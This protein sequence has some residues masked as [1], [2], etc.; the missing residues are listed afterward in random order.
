MKIDKRYRPEL[1]V[2]KGKEPNPLLTDPYLDVAAER[3][4]ST[5]GHGLVALP[6][7][8]EKTERSR[9]LACSLLQA[10]RGLGDED[11]P[12]EIHDQEIVEFGVLWPAAQER[13]FPDWQKLMPKFTRGSPG[14][15]TF[16]LNPEL[17]HKMATAMGIG[18]VCLTI[19]LGHP[20]NLPSP[21]V[22]QPL[23][24][25]AEEI[26]LLMPMGATGAGEGI[27]PPGSVCPQC[28]KIL[29]AGAACPTHGPAARAEMEGAADRLL[30]ESGSGDLTR[31]D[32]K[33]P[34][35]ARKGGRR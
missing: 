16:A 1:V 26:G 34:A 17:L 24:E 3:L 6:V 14:T 18:G 7:E 33:G 13:S 29:A 31:A 11:V 9:Y 22:V 23:N 10:A 25:R 32:T 8:T 2:S 21:I 35:V 5:N 30:R 19:E 28:G 15:A 27:L 20:E 12:A 4:V